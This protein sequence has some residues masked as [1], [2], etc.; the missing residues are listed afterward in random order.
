[1][2]HPKDISILDFTYDLPNEKIAVYPLKNRDESKLLVYRNNTI[3]EDVFKNID[4]FLDSDTVLVF[5][6]TKVIR[7]RL[8]FLNFKGQAI[9]IFCLEPNSLDLELTQAMSA[10]KKI[11]WNCL[12]GNLKRWKDGDLELKNEG[13]SLFAKLVERRE[14]DVLIEFYWEPQDLHFSEVIE[15]MGNTPIPPYLK[16]KSEN[17]DLD[18]YQT[19]Y[20][21]KEGSVAAPTAGLHFTEGVLTAIKKKNIDS[22]SVTLHVGAGTFKPVKAENMFGHEMHAEWIDVS[23]ES[24]VKLLE[25]KEKKIISVGTTSLRTIESLYWMGL[26]TY[27]DKDI[28]L[29][30]LEIKQW[31]AYSLENKRISVELSLNSL[32]TWMDKRGLSKLVCHTQILI[33]PPYELKIARGIITNFHQP[34]STLLLLI[35]SILGERWREIY[36]YALDHN[37]RFLSYGDSSLLLK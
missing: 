18:R 35:S 4:T 30:D 14:L 28:T 20:A 11:Q 3:E 2:K 26:K 34:Q 9:E 36:T 24:I 25:G 12:V 23:R 10:Q 7:A 27:Y 13:I 17:L 5:N 37:F 31:E 33:A 6:T 8:N 32:L 1:M 15:I 21:N 19:I 16:R 22:L 29:K